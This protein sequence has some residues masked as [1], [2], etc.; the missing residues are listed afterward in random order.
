MKKHARFAASSSSRWLNCPASVNLSDKAPPQ[1]ESKA[2]SEGTTAHALMEDA[3][4]LNIKDVV[5]YF[6]NDERFTDEMREHVQTLVDFVY[7]ECKDGVQLL[8][9]E[10]VEV[11]RLH[12]T[13]AFGTVDV[14]IVE[15]FGSLH[16]IDLKFGRGHV[17]HK[18][19]SQMVYYALGLAARD[20]F[21]FEEIKM[22]I[23]QPR[24][25]E[26]KPRTHKMGVAE[27]LEWEGRFKEAIDKAETA[28]GDDANRGSWCQFC[29]AKMI[30][31]AISKGAMRDA[32]LA[33]ESPVQPDPKTLIPSQLKLILDQ[34]A[35][36]ELWIKE[37]KVQAE[38]RL[39]AGE[40]IKGWG[41]K[42]TRPRR[43]WKYQTEVVRFGKMAF[44]EVLLSPSEFEK[45]LKSILPK[46]EIKAF[47]KD[48][49]VSVS[50]GVKLSPTNNELE[51]DGLDD[52][53]FDN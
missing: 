18:D 35:Y 44:K 40:K 38:A 42:E 34:S 23:F 14:A 7:S 25:G 20:N 36:L 33:F 19:N 51:F 2:A 12:E 4:N 17:N 13:E 8:V 15:P 32:K 3:L 43:V 16:I 50:S 28:T 26:G 39:K 6:R 48:N 9:E 46:D 41:L 45:E 30:C 49:V 37:V 22:T 52:L 27:L 24:V 29:P 10:R 31:P 11:P 21:D 53:E 47:L 1:I 5:H